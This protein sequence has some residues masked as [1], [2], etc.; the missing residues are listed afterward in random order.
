MVF[1][2]GTLQA[3]VCGHFPALPVLVER[4]G[5]QHEIPDLGEGSPTCCHIRYGFT[6]IF[7]TL[8]QIKL[9]QVKVEYEFYLMMVADVAAANSPHGAYVST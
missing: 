6:A 8:N 4:S 2:Q 7:K 9:H 5:Q 1:R 3:H